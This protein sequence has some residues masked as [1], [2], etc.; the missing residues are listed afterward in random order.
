MELSHLNEKG[1]ARMVDVSGKSVQRRWARAEGKI[2]LQPQTLALIRDQRVPK[3][4][5]LAVARVAGIA[6]AKKTSDLIPLTHN[7]PLDR[8]EIGF[9]FAADGI[10]ITAEASCDAKTGVEMEAL[11]AVAVAALTI[12]DMCKAVD[13]QM[14]IDAIRLLEKRKRDLPG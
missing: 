8:V 7:L 11:S 5:V 10:R 12:Y 9:E 4:D 13:K 2:V 14:R 3:G 6:A 1:E